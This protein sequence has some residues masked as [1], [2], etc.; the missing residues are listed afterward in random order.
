MGAI[1]VIVPS[2]KSHSDVG[3]IQVAVGL[4]KGLSESVRVWSES[5]WHNILSLATTSGNHYFLATSS[6]FAV[7]SGEESLLVATTTY[8]RYFYVDDVGRDAQ[9][10]ITAGG[11]TND[12]STKRVMVIY[13][14]GNASGSL[15]TYVTRFR[16]TVLVQTD[17]AGGPGQEGPTTGANSRF[18][19]SSNIDHAGTTGSFEINLP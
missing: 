10:N 9:G 17:W 16:H 18:A 14:W 12:P 2:L 11:G 15:A 8:Q 3:K 5:D 13:G 6:P 19:T 7:L 1:A 4:G